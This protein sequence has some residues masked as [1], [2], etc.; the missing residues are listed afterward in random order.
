M[1]IRQRVR[2]QIIF[3]IS[4]T[5]DL[6]HL[7]VALLTTSHMQMVIQDVPE[8]PWRFYFEKK[9]ILGHRANKLVCE[10]NSELNI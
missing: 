1:K 7:S 4:Q 6:K 8:E 9:Y 10:P 5:S 3:T 2:A